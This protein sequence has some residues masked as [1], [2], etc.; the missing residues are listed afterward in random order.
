MN[1]EK[2]QK[3]YTFLKVSELPPV[4]AGTAAPLGSSPHH[5]GHATSPAPGL[6]GNFLVSIVPARGLCRP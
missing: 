6:L 5:E 1:G 2:E 3:F 4:L